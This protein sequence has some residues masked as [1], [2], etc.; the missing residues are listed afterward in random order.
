[1]HSLPT[2]LVG[3]DQEEK[4]QKIRNIYKNKKLLKL[5]LLENL[6]PSYLYRYCVLKAFMAWIF[7]KAKVVVDVKPKNKKIK[8]WKF[9]TNE[10]CCLENSSPLFSAVNFGIY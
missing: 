7:F 1:M 9:K 4:N 10:H 3:S 2:E 5:F 8:I 6:K